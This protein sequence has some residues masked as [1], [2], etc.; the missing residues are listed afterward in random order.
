M[1]HVAI[2]MGGWSSEREVSLRSGAA[3]A[4]ALEGSPYKISLIDVGKNIE[5]VLKDLR[6]DVALNVLHGGF[7]EDG[8]MQ[9]VLEKLRIPYTHSGVHASQ[10][11]M[12]KVRARDVFKKS[13]VPVAEGKTV[14]GSSAAKEHPMQPPYVVKPISGGSSVGVYIVRKDDAPLTEIGSEDENMLVERYVAGSELTCAVMQD[15]ALDIIEIVSDLPFYDYTA[16]YSA[17]G[18]RHI[19]PAQLPPDVYKKIQ[20]YALAA[21][22]ALGCRGVSRTDFRYDASTADL[23]CLEVNTQP[24]MTDTSLVPEIAAKAGYSYPQLVAWMIEDASLDR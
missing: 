20:E 7:G 5:K 1:K 4:K 2:L 23:V 19:L 16:K 11:A 18:S 17:G 10:L 13:G 14:S 9:R 21:H 22:R 24:G 15:K 8:G 12:D 6:P 3:C